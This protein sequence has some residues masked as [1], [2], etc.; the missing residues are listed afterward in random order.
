MQT[1]SQNEW[2]FI[3]H[4]YQWAEC[5]D[6]DMPWFEVNWFCLFQN[7][8]IPSIIIGAALTPRSLLVTDCRPWGGGDTRA[9]SFVVG[10]CWWAGHIANCVF[11][12]FPT[13]LE[14]RSIIPVCLNTDSTMRGTE[15][16]RAVWTFHSYTIRRKYCMS[17]KTHQHCPHGNRKAE[18]VA[19][20][21]VS[22]RENFPF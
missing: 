14:N 5:T 10:S 1:G 4:T 19:V 2:L 22:L 21:T 16:L 20:C 6:Y 18:A 13:K 12:S 7:A 8:D 11:V 15:M 9:G 17:T 3:L